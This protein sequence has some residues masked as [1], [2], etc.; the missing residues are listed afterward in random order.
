MEKEEEKRRDA[1]VPEGSAKGAIPED[2]ES[3]NLDAD[4]LPKMELL[5]SEVIE[6]KI[7]E[8][9]PKVGDLSS[10]PVN[11]KMRRMVV[12]KEEVTW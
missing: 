8:L 9:F 6:Q 11:D 1:E 3:V 10:H 5:S 2:G 7:R 4:Q 12:K